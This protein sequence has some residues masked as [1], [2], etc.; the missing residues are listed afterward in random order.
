MS[1]SHSRSFLLWKS[2]FHVLSFQSTYDTVNLLIPRW[3]EGRDE[4][5]ERNNCRFG[6]GFF[7]PKDC[8]WRGHWKKNMFNR[9]GHQ[10]HNE[11]MWRLKK[12]LHCLELKR[13]T[14]N[15]SHVF[16]VSFS[17]GSSNTLLRFAESQWGEKLFGL[18]DNNFNCYQTVLECLGIV[19]YK[20]DYFNAREIVRTL[21]LHSLCHVHI[22]S[23]FVLFNAMVYIIM[24]VW[25]Q[26]ARLYT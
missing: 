23:V 25:Q 16:F 9:W 1:S 21:L 14:S 3:V 24:S 22:H 26:E 18:A 17:K 10:K 15:I 12:M 20:T 6:Y 4:K 13:K 8:H 19:S 7:T 11:K 2:L 5:V